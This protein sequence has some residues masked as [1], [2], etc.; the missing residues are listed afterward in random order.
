M[1]ANEKAGQSASVVPTAVQ[2][3]E[4]DFLDPRN[5]ISPEVLAAI[6]GMNVQSIY[7]R[8]HAGSDLPPNYKKGRLV[9]FFRP[10]VESWLASGRRVPASVQLANAAQQSHD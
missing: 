6:L 2:A 5:W 9:R 7:N 1:K 3:H 4:H 8:I 10:E